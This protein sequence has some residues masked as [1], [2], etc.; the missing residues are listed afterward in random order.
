MVEQPHDGVSVQVKIGLSGEYAHPMVSNHAT[1]HIYVIEE[2][3]HRDIE[4][5]SCAFSG[6]GLYLYA[7]F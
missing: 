4:G 1:S 3:M 7:S 2:L 6:F 5:N